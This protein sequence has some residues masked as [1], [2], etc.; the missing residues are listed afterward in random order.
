MMGETLSD[1]HGVEAGGTIK[2]MGLLPMDTV[3]AKEKDQNQ[4]GRL[5]LAS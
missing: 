1:P 5:I 2:G 4:S 3:F